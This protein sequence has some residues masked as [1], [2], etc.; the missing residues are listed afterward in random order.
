MRVRNS[1]NTLWG[2]A[3]LF[4]AAFIV[5]NQLGIVI[6]FS[7]W[8]VAAAVLAIKFSLDFIVYRNIKM[9]PLAIAA[10]YIILRNL[11]IV[12]HVSTWAV[13]GAAFIASAGIGLLFPRN[14]WSRKVR[15]NTFSSDDLNMEG[16][17]QETISTD[18]NPSIDVNFGSVSRYLY[19]DELET[20]QLSCNF[21]A[22][23]IY[24]D[25]VQ[26]SKNGATVYLDCKFG[27]IDLYVPRHWNVVEQVNAT[28]GGAEVGR[29]LE[30]LSEDAPTLT[31]VGNVMF[32]AVDINYV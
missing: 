19:A 6:A 17:G 10:V 12:A 27:G 9:L 8:T 26:L 31:V 15:I 7:I 14:F 13:I 23:D 29:R 3:L 28:F 11:G 22:M 1:S 30:P 20:V 4:L 5:L 18:N 32:G 25:Q 24:F 21:A 16:H 2:I